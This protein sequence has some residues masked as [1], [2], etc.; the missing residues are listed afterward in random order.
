MKKSIFVIMVLVSL[1]AIRAFAGEDIKIAVAASDKAPTALVGDQAG[2]AAYFL[3]F[4]EKGRLVETIENPLKNSESPGPEVINFLAE[5]KVTV[6]VAGFF[7]P[8]II[9]IAKTRGIT[10]ITFKGTAQDVVKKIL[11][12]K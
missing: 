3:V 12:S 6:V 11:Q 5:K 7:G 2:A 4:D 9:D 10:P 1:L 8:R